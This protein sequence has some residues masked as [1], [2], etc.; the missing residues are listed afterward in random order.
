MAEVLEVTQRVNARPETVFAFFTDPERYARWQGT[1]A[2]LEPRPG[3]RY[4]VDF[5]GSS[6]VRGEFV[7]VEPPH[8]IVFTWGWEIDRS[9]YPD[10]EL[11]P[12]IEEVAPASTS[13][14]VTLIP[15][16]DGTLV[17]LRHS[18]LPTVDAEAIHGSRWPGYLERLTTAVAGRDP[19][20]DPVATIF[21]S[22]TED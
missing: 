15:D 14:E 11:P 1:A 7:V 10:V 22:V 17:R 21:A 4:E 20:Q 6:G 2:R 12:G 18:G 9:R 3:G 5:I 16:G 13:V 19:G 8:R